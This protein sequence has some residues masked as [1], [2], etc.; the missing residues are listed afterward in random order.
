MRAPGGAELADARVHGYK[1]NRAGWRRGALLLHLIELLAQLPELGAGGA[2]HSVPPRAWSHHRQCHRGV[3]RRPPAGPAPAPLSWP[4]A[5]ARFLAAAGYRRRTCRV[6]RSLLRRVGALLP[7]VPLSSQRKQYL[8]A[9]RGHLL[10]TRAGNLALT[11]TALRSFLLW[12]AEQR[13]HNITAAEIRAAL[14]RPGA[15]P[16]EGGRKRVAHR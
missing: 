1:H 4:D 6:Y 2:V 12:A 3:P 7:Q 15:A 8:A 10:E 5:M 13:L 9:L 14:P 16:G 11:L